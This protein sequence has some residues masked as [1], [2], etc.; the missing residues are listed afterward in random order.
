MQD[1]EEEDAPDSAADPPTGRSLHDLDVGGL[2]M[3][4][5]GSVWMLDRDED[6][7]WTTVRR[8]ITKKT[9]NR[10]ER[11]RKHAPE[12]ERSLL[13]VSRENE[14]T[15][16][17]KEKRKGKYEMIMITAD[18]GAADHV[19]PKNV[20]SHLRIQETEASRQGVKYVAANGQK[21]ANTGQKT[22]RGITNEGMP[23]SIT[24]QL[25]EVKSH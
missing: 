1:L 20:A 2:G 15:S 10:E 5:G 25:A 3:E 6:G 23:L 16:G 21:I 24:W 12:R 4:L 7:P 14:N 22:I 13:E 9:E 18:S 8:R 19:A 11:R 17:M